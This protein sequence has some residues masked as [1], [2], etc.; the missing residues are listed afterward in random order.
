MLLTAMIALDSTS[1]RLTRHELVRRD[2]RRIGCPMICAVYFDVPRGQ[3][4]DYLLQGGF[5]L[6]STLLVQKLACLLI[7]G[8]PN[9][10]IG[11][12]NGLFHRPCASTWCR[13]IWP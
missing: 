8:F 9:L 12:T 2:D 7:E 3:P 5:I 10:S 11:K 4:I 6:P 1:R 13:A